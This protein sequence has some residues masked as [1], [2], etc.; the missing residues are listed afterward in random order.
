MRPSQRPGPGRDLVGRPT[1]GAPHEIDRELG[2]EEGGLPTG[3]QLL[4]ETEQLKRALERR[5]VIDMARGVL[6]A[7]WSCTAEEGWRILVWV[8]QH[9]NTKVH[10]VAE[11]LLATTR[12]EP[13]PPHLEKHLPA[14]LEQW[15]ALRAS[16]SDR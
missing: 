6:M 9:S 4:A 12:N 16:L 7:T 10:D 13:M 14:A 1:R 2:R 8:S 15:R 5:P 3:E 11:A